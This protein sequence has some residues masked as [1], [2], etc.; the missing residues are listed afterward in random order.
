[1]LKDSFK[2]TLRESELES[3]PNLNQGQAILAIK[4]K[5]N[6]QLNIDL[7]KEEIEIFAG[8]H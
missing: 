3:I 2:E 4:G 5:G 8:G 1:E 7:S 6:F